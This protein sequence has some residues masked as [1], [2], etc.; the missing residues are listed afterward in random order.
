LDGDLALR[1]QVAKYYMEH[2]TNPKIV[3]PIVN[4]WD[5]HVFHLFPIRTKSRD[6]LQKYLSDNGVQ[7]IIHYPIPPHQQECYN[8]MN[9]QVYPVTEQI[10][11]EELSLPM[12]PVLTLE[13]IEFIVQV[14]NNWKCI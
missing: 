6:E 10:H 13:E 11:G 9:E 1:K 14:I 5:A 12:S 3:L 7:T 4:D 8:W 2:I